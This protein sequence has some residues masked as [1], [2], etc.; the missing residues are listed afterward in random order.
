MD[1]IKSIELRDANVYPDDR[2][3]QSIIG[4]SFTIYSKLLTLFTESGLVCTWRYYNDGKAW[5]CKVQLKTKTI[6]WMSAW[7]G[8]M[9]VTIYIPEKQL[10]PVYSL[11]LSSEM[12]H[13]IKATKNVGKSKPCIFQ[14]NSDKVLE[15][16][17]QLMQY[18]MSAK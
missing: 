5:L 9:Q 6:A 2:V 17:K 10:E 16:F 7:K 3:L 12:V 13:R 8:Y 15:D 18:K 11:P 1:T 14:M 4:N